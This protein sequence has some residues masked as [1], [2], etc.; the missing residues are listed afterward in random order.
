M[1]IYTV[2]Q[3][4]FKGGLSGNS[5]WVTVWSGTAKSKEEAVKKAKK[6]LSL[7]AEEEQINKKPQQVAR[8]GGKS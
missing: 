1:K 8:A 6:E 7:V 4:Q 3:S 2:K 5:H